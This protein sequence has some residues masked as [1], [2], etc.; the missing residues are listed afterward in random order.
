MS[1]FSEKLHEYI[2]R[3]DMKIAALSKY[4]GVDR[5]FIQKMLSGQRVPSDISTINRLAD[6]L[7]LTPL[8]RRSLLE[9]H[10]ISRM[11]EEVYH[12][13]TTVKRL[14]EDADSYYFHTPPAI[15][16]TLPPP[17][18]IPEVLPFQGKA[19]V[20][21]GLRMLMDAELSDP[22]PQLWV[23]MQPDC[24]FAV[25][26]HNCCRAVPSL[27]IEHILRFD[28]ELQYQRENQHNLHCVRCLLPFLL[29][30]CSYHAWFYYDFAGE[31]KKH[32]SVFPWFVLGKHAALSLSSDCEKGIL[33]SH[34]QV[35]ELFQRIFEEIRSDCLPFFELTNVEASQFWDHQRWP[36][37]HHQMA[38]SLQYEPCWGFFY[39]MDMVEKQ[40][41]KEIPNREEIITFFSHHRQQVSLLEGPMR[42]TAF[43][44]ME[45]LEYFLSTGRL[46]ELPSEIYHPLS[47]QQR[48]ELFRRMVSCIQKGNFLPFL[49]RPQK[50]RLPRKLT[51]FVADEQHLCCSCSHPV[52]GPVSVT[53]REKSVVYSICD[54][55][56]YM[57]ETDMV[58]SRKESES[59]LLHRL[60]EFTKNIENH[61]EQ[62]E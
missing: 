53:L 5:S 61:T 58:Y 36:S 49:V 14:L 59:I 45:G 46:S 20:A 51:F 31:E 27:H 40:L 52:Y 7:M 28:N 18:P 8:E 4:S 15:L 2:S 57:L 47:L 21:D 37:I 34:P 43:F 24:E 60:E 17:A 44:T 11:G 55:L 56:E 54:F 62:E 41:L 38:Y 25:I 48:A 30:P 26:L 39:S 33:Y 23:V 12:R 3:A 1:V 29:S 50:F 6:A 42:C 13:R 32:T 9:A 16:P 35:M 10:A 19:S 22:A